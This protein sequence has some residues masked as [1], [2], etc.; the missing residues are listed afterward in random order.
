[1]DHAML[2]Q[3]FLNGL[4]INYAIYNVVEQISLACHIVDIQLSFG[5]SLSKSLSKVNTIF[6]KYLCA[7]FGL[8]LLLC[9]TINLLKPMISIRK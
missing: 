9:N 7:V 6:C 5:I 8:L 3:H 1:M 4:K 2:S